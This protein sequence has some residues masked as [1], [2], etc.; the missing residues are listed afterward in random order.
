MKALSEI[1]IL[2]T[3]V[4]FKMRNSK[5]RW[6]SS[7][8]SLITMLLVGFLSWVVYIDLSSNNS[9][10]LNQYTF[11]EET[12]END[13]E[14]T[15]HILPIFWLTWSEMQDPGQAGDLPFAIYPSIINLRAS[16]LFFNVEDKEPF[17][18]EYKAIKC[19]ES[20]DKSFEIFQKHYL[21][22]TLED[23]IHF[24]RICFKPQ[25][26]KFLTKKEIKSH[27]ISYKLNEFR[28]SIEYCDPNDPTT[29]D[30]THD[31]ATV[32]LYL[33]LV[34][35][36]LELNTDR[37][38]DVFSEEYKNVFVDKLD[39]KPLHKERY[40]YYQRVEFIENFGDG[41]FHRSTNLKNKTYIPTTS[42]DLYSFGSSP[43]GKYDYVFKI[44]PSRKIFEI[45]RPTFLMGFIR[46]LNIS[47]ILFT[48][49]LAL[50][51]L[52]I[53]FKTDNHIHSFLF[54]YKDKTLKPDF[55]PINKRYYKSWFEVS[56]LEEFDKN[57]PRYTEV[58]KR[59]IL[60]LVGKNWKTL[61]YLKGIRNAV[62]QVI[63]MKNSFYQKILYEAVNDHYVPKHYQILLPLARVHKIIKKKL[64]ER[65][66]GNV[67]LA[68]EQNCRLYQDRH[69][70]LE[71]MLYK[72]NVPIFSRNLT[73]FILKYSP[74]VVV[75]N[76][77]ESFKEKSKILKALE[78]EQTIR[79]SIKILKRNSLKINLNFESEGHN[80]AEMIEEVEVES[81]NDQEEVDV[82]AF[83]LEDEE[84]NDEF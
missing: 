31:M 29:K 56:I 16:H 27:K 70:S 82:D 73:K 35:R 15:D 8:C 78:T 28:F 17:E 10:T 63:D 14:F 80:N 47:K 81:S 77:L 44:E 48:V 2:G 37:V 24:E 61:I 40:F 49:F 65:E 4:T 51:A 52:L 32:D 66:K 6:A 12:V 13:S 26:K 58:E 53:F 41:I 19:V 34:L 71:V 69:N 21:F 55:K 23:E 30:C 3:R 68:L 1:D 11:Y 45:N 79:E 18:V 84:S 46:I 57:K 33:G 7:V 75:K 25:K 39:R 59:K 38:D 76:T 42:E 60:E 67:N 43:R 50:Y 5:A 62:D 64:E 54:N 22:T 83:Q 72:Q 36:D 20:Q 74:A 9:R